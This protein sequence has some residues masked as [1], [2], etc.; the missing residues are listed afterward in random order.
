MAA[1]ASLELSQLLLLRNLTLASGTMPNLQELALRELPA[2]TTVAVE[3]Q[4]STLSRLLL[5]SGGFECS[6][7]RPSVASVLGGERTASKRAF[8]CSAQRDGGDD[9]DSGRHER[10]CGLFRDGLGGCEGAPPR[11]R[12]RGRNADERPTRLLRLRVAAGDFRAGKE[13]LHGRPQPLASRR[14]AED[15]RSGRRSAATE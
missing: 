4:F 15:A 3:A 1:V 12:A 8:L 5:K 10:E 9:F 11:K 14:L 2:L 7:H 13:G 6:F